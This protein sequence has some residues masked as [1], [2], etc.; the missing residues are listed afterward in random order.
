MFEAIAKIGMGLLVIG[1]VA[2]ATVVGVRTNYWR[3]YKD[4]MTFG[5]NGEAI[6]IT[7]LLLA[8]GLAALALLGLVAYGIGNI[9][10]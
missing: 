5:N 4:S 10:I 1:A 8:I 3:A 2:Y 9:I 7:S 6:I